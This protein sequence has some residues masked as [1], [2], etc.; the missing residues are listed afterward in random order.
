MGTVTAI[1]D[2]TMTEIGCLFGLLRTT[3]RSTGIRLR[4]SDNV[5]TLKTLLFAV[6]FFVVIP[7]LLFFSLRRLARPLIRAGQDTSDVNQQFTPAGN[8]K[9]EKIALILCLASSVAGVIALRWFSIDKATSIAASGFCIGANTIIGF[10]QLGKP[11]GT[12]LQVRSRVAATMMLIA[13]VLFTIGWVSK[14]YS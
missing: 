8:I 6:G 7:V 10:G 13:M 12:P 5:N 11:L 14:L 2:K 3:L 9:R 1:S 4:R